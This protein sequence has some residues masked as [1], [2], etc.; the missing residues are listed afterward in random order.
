[1]ILNDGRRVFVTKDGSSKA[2]IFDDFEKMNNYLGASF[3]GRV[4]MAEYN[5]CVNM[6]VNKHLKSRQ[7]LSD[8]IMKYRKP[9]YKFQFAY[10]YKP[11]GAI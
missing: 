8:D 2:I 9:S 6:E 11:G 3:E 1:M 7:E 5:D 4:K 10:G